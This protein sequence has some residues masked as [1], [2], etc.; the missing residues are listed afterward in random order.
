[1]RY[2]NYVWI[3]DKKYPLSFSLFGAQKLIEK[4]GSIEEAMEKVEKSENQAERLAITAD[5]AE[6]LIQ[7]GCE[8]CNEFG[9]ADYKGAPKENG[10]LVPINARKILLLCGINNFKPLMEAIRKT[11][12][13]DQKK[14]INAVQK[15]NSKK[16]K[17]H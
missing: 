2:L 11:V 13:S 6:C 14:K 16:K 9:M 5:Y 10:I 17:N 12:N 4:Y 15:N 1:M 8:Y 3:G 7:N